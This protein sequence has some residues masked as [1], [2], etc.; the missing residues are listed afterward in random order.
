MGVTLVLSTF[1]DS[2]GCARNVLTDKNL[3]V[4]SAYAASEIVA[5]NHPGAT[6]RN[7]YF[8]RSDTAK[9]RGSGPINGA[10]NLSFE[11]SPLATIVAALATTPNRVYNNTCWMPGT[12]ASVGPSSIPLLTSNGAVITSENNVLFA[13]DLTT[14]IGASLAPLGTS[15]I[16]GFQCRF[17]GGRWNFPPIGGSGFQTAI[18]VTSVREGGA[19]IVAVGEW[20][21]LPYPNYTGLSGGALTTLTQ[22]QVTGNS[23]QKHVVSITD[24]SNS[25]VRQL[26]SDTTNW[27]DA[28]GRVVF[29]FTPTAIRI[30]NT[31]GQPWSTGDIWV[32]LDLS[33]YLMDFE[34]GSASPLDVPNPLPSLN[35]SA[36]VN[37]GAGLWAFDDFFG[38]IRGGQTVMGA[39]QPAA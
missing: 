23:T 26:M 38:T 36:R 39:V 1:S 13:P 18:P 28:N 5:C 25:G 27:P 4:T 32:L 11:G 35:S 20:V 19:G 33:D 3:F 22:A 2:A 34:P 10:L 17:K 15:P 12:T 24:Q 6:F 16:A 29:D 30:Q 14:P 21:S 37:N 31:C 7:C 8:Y 9:Q